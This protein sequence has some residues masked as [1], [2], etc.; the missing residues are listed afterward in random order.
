MTSQVSPV[1]RPLTPPFE[2]EKAC[3]QQEISDG[4]D[5]KTLADYVQARITID[6][7]AIKTN[8]TRQFHITSLEKTGKTRPTSA[9]NTIGPVFALLFYPDET[10]FHNTFH[11]VKTLIV[12]IPIE[13][14]SGR[15]YS[16][17][18]QAFSNR[19]ILQIKDHIEKKEESFDIPISSKQIPGVRVTLAGSIPVENCVDP[20]EKSQPTPFELSFNQTI[21]AVEH[22]CWN[23]YGVLAKIGINSGGKESANLGVRVQY[24][25]GLANSMSERYP[26]FYTTCKALATQ[27][28]DTLSEGSS[29]QLNIA[30]CKGHPEGGLDLQLRYFSI[31]WK[32]SRELQELGGRLVR[33]EPK[34]GSTYA[35]TIYVSRLKTLT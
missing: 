24:V 16:M 12:E 10:A 13:K 21:R 4:K 19:I 28:L 5:S 20:S 26:I 8:V 2:F 1:Q 3:N 33:M 6:F 14:A 23:R 18:W 31:Y 35:S 30:S 17:D 29:Q 11:L 32:I 15:P 25:A 34:N 22:A 7:T 9:T 27:I